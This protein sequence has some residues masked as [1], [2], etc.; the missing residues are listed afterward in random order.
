MIERLAPVSEM[1]DDEINKVIFS[2][3]EFVENSDIKSFD[4]SKFINSYLN[5]YWQTEVMN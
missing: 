1:V 4:T 5:L 2:M 3:K